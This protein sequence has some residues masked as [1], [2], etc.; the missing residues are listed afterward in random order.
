[1]IAALICSGSSGQTSTISTRSS[2]RFWVL[3]LPCFW[4]FGVNCSLEVSQVFALSGFVFLLRRSTEPKV[5][6]LSPLR[7][8]GRFLQDISISELLSMKVESSFHLTD[9]NL[10]VF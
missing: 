8:I 7:R 10:D 6:G 5:R 2:G 9:T 3:I 4:D 1:L